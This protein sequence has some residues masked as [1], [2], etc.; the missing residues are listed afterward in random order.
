MIRA[1]V[2][3]R[4]LRHTRRSSKGQ[5]QPAAEEEEES[6]S[7]PAAAARLAADSPGLVAAF[8]LLRLA[9]HRHHWVWKGGKEAGDGVND[10]CA[11][12]RVGKVTISLF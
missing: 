12:R 10:R 1:G 3:F 7:S 8:P 11:H 2:G 4:I 9:P 6:A 5:G